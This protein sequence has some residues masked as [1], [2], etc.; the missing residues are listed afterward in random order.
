MLAV[1]ATRLPGRVL[2]GDATRLPV[3]SG[4]VDAVLM[5]WLLHLLDDATPALEEAVRVLKPGG[6]LI[7][8]VDKSSAYFA[9]PSDIASATAPWRADQKATDRFDLVAA[10]LRQHGLRPVG[11]STFP[12]IGQGRSPRQWREAKPR[13]ARNSDADRALASLPDQDRPRPEP[14]YRLIA[15]V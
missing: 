7:T 5:V 1:A 10:T 3:A 15:F 11:E 9:A 8:T 2:V 4:S 14:I 6:R 12:G 13:W